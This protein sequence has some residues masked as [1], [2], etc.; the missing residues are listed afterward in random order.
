MIDTWAPGH[1]RR[2]GSVT[3]Y[4]YRWQLIRR[5][6]RSVRRGQLSIA[7]FIGNRNVVRTLRRLAGQA[8]V[9]AATVP[10]DA[11]RSPAQ[12]DQWLLDYL[13][14]MADRYEPTPFGGRILLFRSEEE[15]QGLF[16]DWQMGWGPFARGGVD[17]IVLPGDHYTVFQEPGVSGMAAVIHDRAAA[18]S[19]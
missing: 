5:E 19:L 15:P 11:E 2:R 4:A 18:R 8:P 1:V 9:G 12:H 13:Q 3:D 17:T 16:I 10:S 7:Q 6:L 14:R